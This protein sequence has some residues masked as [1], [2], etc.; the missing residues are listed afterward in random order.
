MDPGS[1]GWLEMR[2]EGGT[3]SSQRAC[4]WQA[5]VRGIRSPPLPEGCQIGSKFRDLLVP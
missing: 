1:V 5:G 2:R 3:G 4:P